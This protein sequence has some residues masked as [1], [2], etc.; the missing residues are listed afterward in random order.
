MNAASEDLKFRVAEA[1]I[2]DVG[3][4]YARMD[5]DDVFP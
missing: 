2:E 4:G 3:K 5:A 1:F